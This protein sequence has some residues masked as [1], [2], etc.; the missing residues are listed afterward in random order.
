MTR[1]LIA[2]PSPDVRLLLRR[3]VKRLG[4]EAVELTSRERA[5]PSSADVLL[6][7]PAMRG[8]VE[9]AHTARRFRSGVPIVICSIYSATPELAALEPVAY[10]VKPFRREELARALSRAATPSAH[11]EAA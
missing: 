10:L 5:D 11:I 7:E 6:L 4:F 9:L 8:G 3:A 2:E 1:V